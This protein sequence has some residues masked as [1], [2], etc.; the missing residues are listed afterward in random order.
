M[1]KLHLICRRVPDGIGRYG[2]ECIDRKMHTYVSGK[3]DFDLEEAK[4]LVGGM[5]FLHETK[6][7]KSAFGGVITDVTTV[8]AEGV[9]HQQRVEFTF[10]ASKQG[11]G[12]SW[13]GANHS[14][15]WTSGI[16][17]MS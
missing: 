12:E 1:K 4:Q 5:L 15:A 8:I 16:V 3:W 13:S 2:L 6:S 14:M 11:K 9:R 17:D 7:E 10:T